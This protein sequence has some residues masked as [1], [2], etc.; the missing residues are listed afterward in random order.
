M[1]ER[2]GDRGNAR[3]EQM[4]PDGG[5]ELALHTR[6]ADEAGR[7]DTGICERGQAVRIGQLDGDH[8]LIADG[9]GAQR[10]LGLVGDDHGIG[11]RVI[12]DDRLDQFLHRHGAFEIELDEGAPARP[13]EHFGEAGDAVGRDLALIV[14]E[15]ESGELGEGQV[16]DIA[17]AGGGALQTLVMHHHQHA[18]GGAAHIHLQ[19]HGRAGQRVGKRLDGVFGIARLH[20]A[21]MG[22]DQGDIAIHQAAQHVGDGLACGRIGGDERFGQGGGLAR[23]VGKPLFCFGDGRRRGGRLDLADRFRAGGQHEGKHG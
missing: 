17:G 23:G 7:I 16:G 10:V 2:A 9:G 21:A 4:R 19:E 15:L 22:A 1:P 12:L 13:A 8:H 14:D 11:E 5:V 3:F 6:P 18:V 20:P